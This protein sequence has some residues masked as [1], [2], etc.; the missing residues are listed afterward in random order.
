M[1]EAKAPQE[2]SQVLPHLD[3]AMVPFA[4][5][6]RVCASMSWK[7]GGFPTGH[8]TYHRPGSNFGDSPVSPDIQRERSFSDDGWDYVKT[9]ITYLNLLA[10]GTVFGESESDPLLLSQRIVD[11]FVTQ[12]RPRRYT[13][14]LRI[15]AY[16]LL[17]DFQ[18]RYDSLMP[19]LRRLYQGNGSSGTCIAFTN[20][21]HDLQKAQKGIIPLDDPESAYSFRRGQFIG[22]MTPY[23]KTGDTKA[24]TETIVAQIQCAGQAFAHTIRK[25]SL[26]AAAELVRRRSS[27]RHSEMKED[28]HM[29]GRVE[30][31]DYVEGLY[32]E[33]AAKYS[34]N[35]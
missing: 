32:Q 31:V 26:L 10:D 8:R 25:Q 16:D 24:D 21:T 14:A 17:R 11:A 33:T 5:V 28:E 4:D 35:P 30:I 6:D 22:T 2:V 7:R 3:P 18:V 20:A 34:S 12:Q 27:Y 23:T 9:A 19:A 29:F 13:L 15:A 1:I